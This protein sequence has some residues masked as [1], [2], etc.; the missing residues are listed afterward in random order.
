MHVLLI[1]CCSVA[2]LKLIQGGVIIIIFLIPKLFDTD[3]YHSTPHPVRRLLEF[4]NIEFIL[5]NRKLIINC[6]YFN[7]VVDLTCIELVDLHHPVV[8]HQLLHK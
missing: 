3:S 5:F 2:Y 6:T 1:I 4:N 8:D 7:F